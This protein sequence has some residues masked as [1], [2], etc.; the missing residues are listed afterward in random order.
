MESSLSVVVQLPPLLLWYKIKMSCW[1][2]ALLASGAVK[3]YGKFCVPHVF[4]LLHYD[5][6]YNLLD[7]RAIWA[8]QLFLLK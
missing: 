1:L 8:A 5:S 2:L 4:Q 3:A 7:V 6:M